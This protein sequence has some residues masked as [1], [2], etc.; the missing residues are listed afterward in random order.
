MPEAG[1]QGEI[2]IYCGDGKGKSTAAAGLALRALGAGLSVRFVQFIKDGSSSEFTIL[3]G[4][5]RFDYFAAGLGR[6]IRRGG[7]GP[8]DLAKAAEGLAL[9]L[10]SLKKADFDLL[11]LDEIFAALN[12]GLVPKDEFVAALKSRDPRMEVVLTGR[13]PA[14]EIAEL[15]GLVSEVRCVK[16]YYTRGRKALKGIEF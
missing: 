12:Y 16:H 3:R 10:D 15:A 5:E 4:L 6:F 7:P 1:A 13:D 14:P 8:D 2:H 9:A 11:V